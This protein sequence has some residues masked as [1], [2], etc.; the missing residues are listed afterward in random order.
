MKKT[1]DRHNPIHVMQVLHNV[2]I[3]G[4]EKLA[5]D[6][7]KNFDSSCS[8]SFACLDS[9][10]YLGEKITDEGF[11]LHCFNRKEGWDWTLIKEF[12]RVITEQKV[13]V[14]HAHQY[15]PYFYAVLASFFSK[16]NPKVIFTEHGRHQPDKVRWKRVIFNKLFQLFTHGYT[17]VSQFSKDSLVEFEKIPARRIEVIYNGIDLTQFPKKYDAVSIRQ[18][19]NLPTDVPLVGII[20]RLDPIKDHKT[21]I[22]SMNY[23]KNTTSVL[24]VVGDGPI[25]ADL[26]QQ[27]ADLNLSNRIKFL[28]MCTNVP[29]I[30]MALDVFVLPSIMEATSVTLLEAMG[31]GLPVVVTGVGGNTEIV[32]DGQ[33]GF[34]VP[35]ENPEALAGAIEKVLADKS[36]ATQMGNAGRSRVEEL[37][38]FEKMIEKYRLMYTELVR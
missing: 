12:S 30:L 5:F 36:N 31:A 32:L 28:G 38:L 15:T 18:K 20:A 9:V 21:L 37:F 7:A 23:M 19:L 34:L 1:K 11:S 25:R 16:R 13:D 35:A 24:L 33:T 3:G 26:E 6:I 17:G 4:A 2:E 8:F 29:E 22:Q 14:L 10:G 27:V